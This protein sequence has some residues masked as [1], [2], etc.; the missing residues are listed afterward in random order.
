MKEALSNK[1]THNTKSEDDRDGLLDGD[2][3]HNTDQDDRISRP[4]DSYGAYGRFSVA[5]RGS[6][7]TNPIGQMADRKMCNVDP[8]GMAEAAKATDDGTSWFVWHRNARLQPSM[9]GMRCCKRGFD[10]WLKHALFDAHR[11]V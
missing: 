11:T 8:A 9:Q 2:S 10:R 7:W 1:R 4:S 3:Q 6:D 5:D